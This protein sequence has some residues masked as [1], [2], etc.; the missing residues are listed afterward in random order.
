MG[1]RLDWDIETERKNIKDVGKDPESTR[2]RRVLRFR[3]LATV[4]IVVMIVAG[5]VGFVHYRTHK[6]K[7]QLEQT[8]RDTVVAEVT[9]LRLGD[10]RTFE[11]FQRSA[12]EDWLEQQNALFDWYQQNM[13]GEDTDVRLTG[14]ILALEIDDLRAR[15]HVQEI[16]NGVPYTRVWSYWR[17][18][19]DD[20][21]DGLLDGWRHVPLDPTFWGEA[22]IYQGHSVTVTY[23]GIDQEFAALVGSSI[24]NW[25]GVACAALT[26]DNLPPIRVDVLSQGV[27]RMEWSPDDPWRLR[28]P[29]PYLVRARSD[30]PF[31]PELQIEVA[32]LLAERLM[33]YTSGDVR[34]E[35]PSDAYYLQQAVISWLVGRFAQV[36]TRS[37]LI[38]SLTAN[39]G[40]TT[41]GRLLRLMP[42]DAN[43][44]ILSQVTGA[45]LDQSN[46]DWRD[47]FTWRLTVEG[48][49]VVQQNIEALMALYDT[50]DEA[51]LAAA[52]SRFEQPPVE[53]IEVT[54]TRLHDAA[55]DGSPQQAVTVR[56]GEGANN[57]EF[58]ILFRLVNN[59]W[60]R[61]S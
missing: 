23:Q 22:G 37:F 11:G 58:Q 32:T 7:S 39:Y 51:I 49:L 50:R 2:K 1:V 45:S 46:L 21:Q 13:Q 27:T 20:D 34:A 25:I 12:S 47:F 36:D 18:E 16:I 42:P 4:I 57:V 43:I 41:V 26:C 24:D 40:E 8:L 29:S 14:H 19:T 9:A 28:I 15:V 3:L 54:V 35:Y 53:S 44:G 38:A 17:Y 56:V 60:L 5:G 33:L 31:S 30:Q 55:P 48:E 59:N 61:A 52:Y 6:V 10:R